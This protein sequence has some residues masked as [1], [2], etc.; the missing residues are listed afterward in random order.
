MKLLASA[1][2]AFSICQTSAGGIAAT[3]RKARP[4]TTGSP[5]GGRHRVVY[6]GRDLLPAATTE[7]FPLSRR[8]SDAGQI[9]RSDFAKRRLDI[10]SAILIEMR[11]PYEHW[12]DTSGQ[13]TRNGSRTFR[14]IVAIRHFHQIS[15][16]SAIRRR[17]SG[18]PQP[19]RANQVKWRPL[20]ECL[21][22]RDRSDRERQMATTL[23]RP[24]SALS[25]AQ[26][27]SG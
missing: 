14:S 25:Y 9:H 2:V 3:R 5:A 22:I 12:P 21:H 8:K 6:A 24:L 4:S 18:L 15:A 26:P 10:G 17:S 27:C 11:E 23:H 1:I 16:K 19:A 7:G 20:G 13:G